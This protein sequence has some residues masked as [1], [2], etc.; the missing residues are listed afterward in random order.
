MYWRID[1]NEIEYHISYCCSYLQQFFLSYPQGKC[2]CCVM[3]KSA[4]IKVI[5]H[6]PEDKKT[7]DQIYIEAVIE[8]I[9]QLAE[10]AK[11]E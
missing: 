6:L 3:R 8:A 9:K 1:F 10:T 2:R 5:V 4:P 7:F 11:S